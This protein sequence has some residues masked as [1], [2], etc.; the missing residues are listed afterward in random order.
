MCQPGSALSTAAAVSPQQYGYNPAPVPVQ[1]QQYNNP[2]TTAPN[3]N[4]NIANDANYTYNP[5]TG[6]YEYNPRSND[7]NYKYN[8]QTGLYDYFEPKTNRP[9]A[10]LEG[11]NLAPSPSQYNTG[12][13]N[14]PAEP[15]ARPDIFDENQPVNGGGKQFT[16]KTPPTVQYFGEH[17]VKQGE[18]LRSIAIIYGISTAEL[19]Q[20]NSISETESLM[21]G[22][23]L[24][25]PRK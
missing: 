18:N 16:P 8:P 5:T 21:P 6:L 12:K 15:E 2:N 14:N 22:K 17:S 11:S 20:L 3:P 10:F 4:Y 13:P 25:V 24:V 9:G 7:A 19:A 23:R 1:P